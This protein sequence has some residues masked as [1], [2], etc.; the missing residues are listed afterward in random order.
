MSMPSRRNAQCANTLDAR[1]R[2]MQYKRRM[3]GTFTRLQKLLNLK[4]KSSIVNS[5]INSIQW[6]KW[7]IVIQ[8]P[9]AV[10]TLEQRVVHTVPVGAVAV[11]SA[12][13]GAVA[14]GAASM[15]EPPVQQMQVAEHL[16]S[17]SDL[18]SVDQCVGAD[19]LRPWQ[20]SV[21]SAQKL[22]HLS[23]LRM[24]AEVAAREDQLQSRR[25]LNAARHEEWPSD[26]K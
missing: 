7:H 17:L 6:L 22:Q 14:V 18:E 20:V 5:L 2:Q 24:L 10:A 1:T 16:H 8:K 19:A 15:P 11:G 25:N 26:H 3:T 13:V 12:A 21:S 9:Q 23:A 4:T